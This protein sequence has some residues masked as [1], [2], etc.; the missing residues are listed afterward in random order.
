M[1][2]GIISFAHM[3]A[4]SYAAAL[5]KHKEAELAGIWDAN[6]ERGQAKANEFQSTFYASLDELLSSNID[7]VII[8]SENVNHREHVIKAA[9]YQ[10]HILCEKPIATELSDAIEMI[11]A[12]E[13]H[14]V[15][16]QVAYPVR[17]S[18][19]IQ[20]MNAM[21]GSGEIGDV[22]AVNATNHGQMP[23]GWFVQKDQSGGGAAT[24]HIV[25]LMDL[26]RWTLKDEVASVYAEFDQRFY[27]IEVEDCGLVQLEME[28]GTLVTIDPSWSRPKS[29]PTWGDVTLEIVGTKGVLS[30][31]ALKQHSVLYN[32]EI[33]RIERKSW[34]AD[35][36]EL[37]VDDFIDCVKTGRAPFISGEDG[38]RTLEVVKAAYQSDHEKQ[39]IKLNRITY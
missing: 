35:M 14:Q 32:D 5:N 38:L 18:E 17:F 10:K 36:D 15:T 30:V 31:D 37:L 29:F 11:L 24:D 6:S 26:L 4:N 34:A 25:H 27:D 22:L 28:S 12:C 39:S 33:N 23:G 2:I 7:A 19:P 13:Q 21:I 8:C 16:L 3:H 9:E 20:E 1:K